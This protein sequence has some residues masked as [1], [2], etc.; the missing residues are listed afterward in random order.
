M[1]I[2]KK[3]SLIP[4]ALA[5]LLP[6]VLIGAVV[7]TSQQ[8]RAPAEDKPVTT[9]YGQAYISV[10]V[11]DRDGQPQPGRLVTLVQD[12]PGY[13]APTVPLQQPTDSGGFAVFTAVKVGTIA[14]GVVG[15]TESAR[16]TKLETVPNKTFGVELI[17]DPLPPGS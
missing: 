11:K 9:R 17:V 1:E 6:C 3:P 8:R 15:S 5:F 7:L 14:I 4:F 2:D 12:T 13:N 16:L 10:F